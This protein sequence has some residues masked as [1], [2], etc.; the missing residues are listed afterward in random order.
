ML[1][2]IF[3][4]YRLLAPHTSAEL[5]RAKSEDANSPTRIRRE[6]ALFVRRL[7]YRRNAPPPIDVPIKRKDTVKFNIK[8]S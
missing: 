6:K 1:L 5:I 3:S 4:P 7:V 2:Y 8:T